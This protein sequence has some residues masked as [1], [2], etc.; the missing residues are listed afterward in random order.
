[1]KKAVLTVLASLLLSPSAF[2]DEA[3]SSDTAIWR[4]NYTRG[5]IALCAENYSDAEMYL[6]K[7]RV[8][9][10]NFKPGDSRFFA[11][12]TD[13]I[14]L[15]KKRNDDTKYEAHLIQ[16][17]AAYLKA[18][19]PT[20]CEVGLADAAH[21]D[22]YDKLGKL[23]EA[24]KSYKAAIVVVEQ[25][26]GSDHPRLA[27]ICHSC[28][29]L[30]WEIGKPAE[31]LK[32]IQKEQGILEKI[33]PSCDDKILDNLLVQGY[34]FESLFMPKESQMAWGK[35]YALQAKSKTLSPNE[36]SAEKTN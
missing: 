13:L 9:A 20:Y 34:V 10:Q 1:M 31:A 19:G 24:E 6:E 22:L 29:V 17:R 18:F 12:M 16:Q 28:A 5:Q 15:D 21:G 2:A 27:E 23:S 7:A 14:E 25:A 11:I 30:Q 26:L 3:I 36:E 35:Y 4:E 8:V 32:M 33:V